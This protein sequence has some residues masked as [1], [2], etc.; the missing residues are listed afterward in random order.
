MKWEVEFR[1]SGFNDKI[2][3]RFFFSRRCFFFSARQ[4]IQP[5]ALTMVYRCPPTDLHPIFEWILVPEHGHDFRDASPTC[6]WVDC[7]VWFGLVRLDTK[8]MVLNLC[9]RA[10][11]DS[12][13]KHGGDYPDQ[14]GYN[15]RGQVFYTWLRKD[16]IIG[17]FVP[18]AALAFFNN[19]DQVLSL[20]QH[21]I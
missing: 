20:H 16:S 18:G 3:Y 9:L 8:T 12:C 4:S 11:S 7:C 6:L 14:F 13:N 10:I 1:S 17:F 21:S 5:W 19:T 2:P 15:L